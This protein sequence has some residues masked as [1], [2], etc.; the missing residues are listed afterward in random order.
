MAD[1]PV[2]D[3]TH[4]VVHSTGRQ[5]ALRGLPGRTRH[6]ADSE[7]PDA[8]DE[9]AAGDSLALSGGQLAELPSDLD[10]ETDMENG[11]R[12]VMDDY[13]DED[14]GGGGGGSFGALRPDS[15]QV[16]FPS[17]MHE[18]HSTHSA[19]TQTGSRDFLQE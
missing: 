13:L 19:L 3:Q 4:H 5:A 1:E 10:E 7:S 15:G 14:S 17:A 18:S 6:L 2:V 8:T 9:T 12:L 11:G 16:S